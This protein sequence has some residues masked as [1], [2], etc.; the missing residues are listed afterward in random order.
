MVPSPSDLAIYGGRR[1]VRFPR[2]DRWRRV[3]LKALWRIGLFGL[4]DVSTAVRG[5][6]IATLE[7]AFARLTQ[8]KHA[9]VMNSGTATLHSAYFA[10][11]VQPS[12]EVIVP[13][14]TFFASAAPILQLG[15]RPVFCD[16][17]P[18][19]LTA[20]PDDVERRITNRT[21]AICVVHVW[22]NPAR[23]DRFVEIAKKHDIALIEDC[24]HAHGATFQGRPVGSWGDVGCFSLQG[25]KPVG[26]GEMGVAVTNRSELFDRMLAFGHFGRLNNDQT[27]GVFPRDLPSLGLKYRPHLY[28]VV[29]AQESLRRLTELNRRR[30]TN[31]A[32]LSDAL[33][34]CDALEPIQT[35]DDAERGGLLEFILRYYPE[36]VGGWNIGAF[37]AAARAEGVPVDVDRYTRQGTHAAMVNRLPVFASDVG[38]ETTTDVGRSGTDEITLGL[39]VAEHM[40][41]RLLTLPPFT[42]VSRRTVRGY[43]AA[44]RKVATVAA[45]CPDLR[46]WEAL[47]GNDAQPG[48]RNASLPSAAQ[49]GQG[50]SNPLDR[51][52]AA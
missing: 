14:Y 7:R 8:T 37:A 20:D 33:A 29:L 4:R 23:M 52:T 17:D 44:L 42:K 39:P 22:G 31:Y 40:L 30:R 12:D 32:V 36:R 9:L 46:R 2:R 48:G 50:V 18:H 28:G 35:Y 3:P 16:I 49:V 47:G 41:D 43:A 1:E 15:A 13:V 51:H 27:V 6:S 38:S 11:G 10:V 45:N 25:S 5:G 19:T 34:G 26:G 21:R 24:S